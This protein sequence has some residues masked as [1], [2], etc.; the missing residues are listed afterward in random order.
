MFVNSTITVGVTQ[1]VVATLVACALVMASIGVYQTAHA[2]NLTNVSNTLST[3][4]PSVASAHTILFTATNDIGP[5]ENITVT[6]DSQD[7]GG[8]GQDFGGIAG[9]T[10]AANL[11]V[12]INGGAGA[13]PTFVSSDAD[14]LEINGVTATAGQTVEIEVAVGAGIINPT[15]LDSYEV[16]IEVANTE[17]DI[18]RT[19]VVILDQVV[20]TAIVPTIF[21]FVVDGLATTTDVNGEATTGSTTPTA[22]PFGV[23]EAGTPKFM[24]QQLSVETNADN[25]FTVSVEQDGPLA[26]SFGADIDSFFDGTDELTPSP[27]ASPNGTLA[28]GENGWG[29]WGLTTEDGDLNN[30][31]A[32]DFTGTDQYIAVLSTP[33]IIFGHTSVCDGATTGGGD[34]TTDD[35]CLTQVGYKIEITPL[36]EAGDDYTTNLMYIATPRF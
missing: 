20:V 26:S 19:R 17:N 29:H 10:T 11:L 12:S 36:Q 21:E 32:T 3:S 25:G 4:E 16:L 2:A 34:A 27:W 14:S 8:V 13:A 18:G 28:F 31:A 15:T 1:R 35:A 6:W 5:A 33:T 23:L 9:I 30:G 7:D 22:I 24:G